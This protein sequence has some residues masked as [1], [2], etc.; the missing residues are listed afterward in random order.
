[1][2]HLSIPKRSEIV[3]SYTNLLEENG[4]LIIVEPAELRHA[5]SLRRLQKELMKGGLHVYAPCSYLWGSNCD[6]AECWT[7]REDAPIQ[8][9]GL[10][11]LLAGEDEGY[12]FINTDIK[13][14]Y[15]IMTKSEKVRCSYRVPRKNR[16][17]RLSQLDRFES[18]VI[19]VAGA[20]MSAD[21]GTGGMH[22]MKICDGTCR[23]PVYAVLSGR[24]RRPGHSALF[25]A[26]Y[27]EVLTLSGVQVRR[28]TKHDA[29]NLIIR[30][31]SEIVRVEPPKR[32]G[33]GAEK[34]TIPPDTTAEL[35]GTAIKQQIPSKTRKTDTR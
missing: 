9:T 31:D 28:H 14:S 11:K 33:N 6:P 2:E 16:M 21:I 8:A 23:E 12:R 27:G 25:S 30:P 5:T 15:L 34:Q 3:L 13:Y 22:I 24:N 10:M 35:T 4:F 26:E 7:F 1:V 29:W 18:R 19:S 20:R 32:P 17:V